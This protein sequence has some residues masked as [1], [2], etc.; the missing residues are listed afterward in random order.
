ML[1]T[2]LRPTCSKV[3]SAENAQV[4][5][6]G[7]AAWVPQIGK[8]VWYLSKYV[9]KCPQKVNTT[10]TRNET[11]QTRL[12]GWICHFEV[13]MHLSMRHMT[14]TSI[15]TTW[16]W[17]WVAWQTASFDLSQWAKSRQWGWYLISWHAPFADWLR[18]P[19][20]DCHL[21]HIMNWGEL[22]SRRWL[23]VLMLTKLI[24]WMLTWT[25]GTCLWPVQILWHDLI[26]PKV[27]LPELIVS[28][29]EPAL[30]LELFLPRLKLDW[31]TSIDCESLISHGLTRMS[32]T[33]K[34]RS[35]SN[36]VML[37]L[38]FPPEKKFSMWGWLWRMILRMRSVSLT[39]VLRMI[40][41]IVSDMYHEATETDSW[42][43]TCW[44]MN[45][46]ADWVMLNNSIWADQIWWFEKNWWSLTFLCMTSSVNDIDSGSM[47]MRKIL[48]LTSSDTS[49]M[50]WTLPLSVPEYM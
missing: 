18:N 3:C 33:A 47:T 24:H 28:T 17:L 22:L 2:C 1:R 5:T 50:S 27:S 42:K 38:S 23:W 19:D 31:S 32:T 14:M 41:R 11:D 39:C 13:V 49:G 7:V 46:E 15:E 44:V 30:E 10:R 48:A 16:W 20:Y 6:C 35:I 9:T 4:D 45:D 34:L 37:D 29:A 21:P 26:Q 36:S 8:N 25:W 43:R 12:W 40:S